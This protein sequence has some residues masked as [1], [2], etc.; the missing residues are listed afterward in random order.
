[1]P[2]TVRNWHS[3]LKM[4]KLNEFPANIQPSFI[5]EARHQRMGLSCGAGNV[6]KHYTKLGPGLFWQELYSLKLGTIT[7]LT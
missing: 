1:M 6:N 7:L 5:L 4:Q 3:D 2:L